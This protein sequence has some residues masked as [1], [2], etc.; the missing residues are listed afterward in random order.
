ML[1][2][3]RDP[4]GKRDEVVAR[5]DVTLHAELHW[6]EGGDHDL[7]PLRSLGSTQQALIAEAAAKAAGF[8]ACHSH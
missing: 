8:I 1:Q 3:S 6:L 7:K 4:F 2:G 5:Q